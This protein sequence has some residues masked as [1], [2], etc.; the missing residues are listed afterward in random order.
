MECGVSWG[1]FLA[2]VE[3]GSGQW[4]P[5]AREVPAGRGAPLL[6]AHWGEVSMGVVGYGCAGQSPPMGHPE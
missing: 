4:L 6:C 1:G 2:T 3:G 5:L